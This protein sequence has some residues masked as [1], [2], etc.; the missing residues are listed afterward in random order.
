VT[1]KIR[2]RIGDKASRKG[3]GGGHSGRLN[4]KPFSK[5]A[6]QE[7]Q[8]ALMGKKESKKEFRVGRWRESG[9][10]EVTLTHKWVN[11]G[12]EG[13][14][15]EKVQKRA[16][17]IYTKVSDHREG[18]AKKGRARKGHGDLQ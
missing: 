4:F 7:K 16:G 6:P 17:W 15:T 5:R 8:R 2:K 13:R 12:G 18:G 14:I 3:I 9:D 11:K 10:L 1:S